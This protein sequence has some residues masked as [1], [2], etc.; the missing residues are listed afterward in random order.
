MPLSP[1]AYRLLLRPLL[2]RL[3]PETAQSL[4][5]LA[6]KQRWLWR[7]AARPADLRL[8]ARLAGLDLPNPI[9]LA[10]GY[11]KDCR[12]LS[13]LADLGFGYIT[14]GTVTANPQAGNPRPR[15]L[16]DVRREAL[17]NSLG[18]PSKGL[19]HVCR[20]LEERRDLTTAPTVVSVSGTTV[21]DILLCHRRVEPLAD[22][23]E[24]NIS[25][26][27][28]AGL[29]VF[30]EA[31]ALAEL[32]GRVNERRQKPLF[33]KIPPYSSEPLKLEA[34]SPPPE[35]IMD[36]VR[37]CVSEGIDALTVANTHPVEDP[38]LAVGSGGLSG[39]PIFQ[40][41]LRM[42]R[43]VRREA[44]SRT[45]INACGG[46]F[47]GDDAWEALRAGADTVQLLTGLI[48][49]GPGVVRSI[50]QELLRRMEREGG[51]YPFSPGGRRLG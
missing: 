32:L 27:N 7:M 16:R 38:R 31:G 9:G 8:K 50:L 43:E 34:S 20:R 4:A 45:A 36:L 30:Q 19:D 41:T 23:V 25:S 12:L 44:G 28:T 37:T 46:V 26:P 49:R 3:P 18:F 15:V 11:D 14:G 5:D 22:A 10:A 40:Q 48:Y 35:K 1:R 17:I 6:L 47:T 24:I 2:F 33:V 21:G 42:V 51:S 39:R 13:P 29:R